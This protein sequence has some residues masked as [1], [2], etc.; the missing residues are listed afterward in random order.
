M[1]ELSYLA[2]L[3]QRARWEAAHARPYFAYRLYMEAWSRLPDGARAEHGPPLLNAALDLC[4]DYLEKDAVEIVQVTDVLLALRPEADARALVA[5]GVARS[6][7]A[8][9]VRRTGAHEDAWSTARAGVVDLVAA[10]K[11]MSVDADAWGSLG[12][13]YKRMGAWARADGDADGARELDRLMLD[14]YAQGKRGNRDAYNVLNFL[15]YRAVVS[16]R[17][18]A[19]LTT[20]AQRPPLL[21]MVRSEAEREELARA[22]EVRQHQ[23]RRSEDAPWAAFDL[24]RGQHYLKPNVLRFL[25]DL[26]VAVEDARRAARGASDRWMVETAQTSLRD[27]YDAGYPLDG[28]DDALL[29]LGRAASDEEWSAGSWAPLARAD[30]YLADELR[31]ARTGLVRLAEVTAEQRVSFEVNRSTR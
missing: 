30:G 2:P 4:L 16:A 21:R 10:T 7:T 12:G 19:A 13:L 8:R 24:A 6:L 29:L 9:A 23:F 27:L 26:G 25:S 1:S 5:R 18:V 11:L 15:E 31:E 17:A 28:L 3:L 14:A 20:E 22:L